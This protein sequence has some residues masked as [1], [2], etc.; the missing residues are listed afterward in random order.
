MLTPLN[1]MTSLSIVLYDIGCD[2]MDEFDD[3]VTR[4]EEPFHTIVVINAAQGSINNGGMRY[5]FGMDWPGCPKYQVFVDAYERIGNAE[6]A[7]SLRDAANSFGVA[8]PEQDLD[9]RLEFIDE[10]YDKDKFQVRGWNDVIC[11]NDSV[12]TNLERWT[13]AFIRSQN[14]HA[15]MDE[16]SDAPKDWVSRF[17]NGNST[18]G[19]R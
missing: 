2:Q 18:A 17:D 3:D 15:S 12:W 7:T 13:R 9:L 6:C 8:D 16:P 11:G 10:Q 5:F 19:P 4:L 1:T 14:L